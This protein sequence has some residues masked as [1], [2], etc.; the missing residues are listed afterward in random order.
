MSNLTSVVSLNLNI[1]QLE[2]V[3]NSIELLKA[4]SIYPTKSLSSE[5]SI[6]KIFDDIK[7]ARDC[8]QDIHYITRFC[9]C[10]N[11]SATPKILICK[12]EI[13]ESFNDENLE[14]IREKYLNKEINEVV[15]KLQKMTFDI[16][17]MIYALRMSLR[18]LTEIF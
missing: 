3:K 9:G 7:C 4:F 2:T 1:K 5:S 16:T 8:I 18:T 11:T 15:L 14:N 12:A 13:V 10:A 17:E 6:L